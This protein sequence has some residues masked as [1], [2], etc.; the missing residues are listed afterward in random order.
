MFVQEMVESLDH[1]NI[2]KECDLVFNVEIHAEILH[3]IKI[4][5]AIMLIQKIWDTPRWHKNSIFEIGYSQ[6]NTYMDCD[7]K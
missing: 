3:I 7:R 2:L 5:V 6:S 1:L 4:I